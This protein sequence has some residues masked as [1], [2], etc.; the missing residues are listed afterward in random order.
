MGT[1]PWVLHKLQHSGTV[2]TT[3]TAFALLACMLIGADIGD[4]SC[5]K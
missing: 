5:F 4:Y 3:L 2:V 1:V